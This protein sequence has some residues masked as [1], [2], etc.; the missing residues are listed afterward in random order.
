MSRFTK[1]MTIVQNAPRLNRSNLKEALL[2]IEDAAERSDIIV[3]PELSL[4]GYMLQ[5]KLHEDAWQ[6]DELDALREASLAIDIVIGAAIRE[7]NGFYNAALY[8]SQ[9]SLNHIHHKVHLP[10]YGMFEEARY[11]RP[12]S[13]IGSFKTRFGRAAMLVCEDLWEVNLLEDLEDEHPEI[14]YILAASPARGFSDGG[15]AI[16][17]TWQKLLEKAAVDMQAEVVFVNRV[18]FEDG[19]GFWGGS[20]VIT[21]EGETAYLADKFANSTETV[22]LGQ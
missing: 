11:F 17:A 2:L 13:R 10:N 21:P 8:F 9:G 20:R 7:E 14:I 18:G 15:L 19:L 4:N 5:D 3:F 1:G 16:E 12:G 22:K 6:L